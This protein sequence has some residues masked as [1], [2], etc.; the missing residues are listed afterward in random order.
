MCRLQVLSFFFCCVF[1]LPRTQYKVAQRTPATRSERLN[2]QAV[3]FV[4]RPLGGIHNSKR[5]LRVGTTNGGGTE[6]LISFG[7]R[8]L[9]CAFSK[10]GLPRVVRRSRILA[11]RNALNMSSR[12]K[13]R[14]LPS[15]SNAILR[16][17]EDPSAALGMTVKPETTV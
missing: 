2:R 6:S 10:R 1:T 4:V 16:T 8:K 3:S 5:R 12:A 17:E 15:I 9:A 7:V 13:P 11:A 14:D